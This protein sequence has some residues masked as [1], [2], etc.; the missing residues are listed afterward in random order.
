MIPILNKF[1]GIINQSEE[2]VC[3]Y[4]QMKLI[5]SYYLLFKVLS[6]TIL[7]II[8]VRGNCENKTVLTN[9]A[10]ESFIQMIYV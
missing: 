2:Y 8:G 6:T 5:I 4:N 9:S 7:H 1:S 10:I 3:L